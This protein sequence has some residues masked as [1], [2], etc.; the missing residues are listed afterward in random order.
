MSMLEN[1]FDIQKESLYNLLCSNCIL[2]VNPLY[3][4]NGIADFFA[5]DTI[6]DLYRTLFIFV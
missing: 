4:I 5:G 6:G 3:Y 2:E 1:F